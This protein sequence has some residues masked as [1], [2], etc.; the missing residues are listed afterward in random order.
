MMKIELVPVTDEDV[1]PL[2]RIMKRAFDKDCQLHTGRDGGPPG[3]DNGDFIR[4]WVF[5]QYA[6]SFKILVDEKLA[7]NISLFINSRT[8][9]N[10]LGNFF[11]DPD[12]HS[13]GIGTRVW[14]MIEEKYPETIKWKTETIWQSSYNHYFY[15]TKCG[16]HIV[17]IDNPLNNPEAQ[18]HMEKNMPL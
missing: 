5:H 18:Y 4:T 2:T 12:F 17:H 1:T 15:V 11:I 8:N 9:V 13:C 10:V 6:T 3:Y 7:G 16:F 14:A